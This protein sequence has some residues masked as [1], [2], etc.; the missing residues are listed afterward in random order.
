[1]RLSDNVRGR[2]IDVKVGN[3]AAENIQIPPLR[4]NSK[5]LEI[6]TRSES[7]F[8]SQEMQQI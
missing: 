1:M 6:R 7:F 4:Q 8:F 2:I 5:Y 3:S